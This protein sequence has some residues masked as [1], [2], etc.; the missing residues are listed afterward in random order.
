[1]PPLVSVLITVY[2]REKYVAAAI[3]SVLAQT[4]SNFELI[5]VDDGSKDRSVEIARRYEKDTRVRVHVNERNLGDYPNRNRAASLARGK[6]LKYVD[7]DDLI[8]PHCLEMMVEG[9]EAFP[10]AAFGV[11]RSVQGLVC[12]ALLSPRDAY[13]LHFFRGGLFGVGPLDTI[14]RR[15]AFEAIG[16]FDTAR[17]TGDSRCWLTL[18]RRS[19]V[20]IIV[21]CLV[22]WR[23]HDAQESIIERQ[24]YEAIADVTGRRFRQL[25][26]ALDAPDCPL[27]ELERRAVRSETVHAYARGIWGRLIRGQFRYAQALL[28][29][30]GQ[31]VPVL[32]KALL[33]PS[34][35]RPPVPAP[36]SPISYLPSPPSGSQSS[37]GASQSGPSSRG[38]VVSSAPSPRAEVRSQR[39]E[40]GGQRSEVREQ[41]APSANTQTTAH[42]ASDFSFQLSAF[43]VSPL[44]SVLIP[45]YNAEARLAEAVESVLAQRFTDWELI[46]VDDASTDRTGEIARGHADGTRIRYFRN[47]HNLGKWPNHNRCAELARGKHLK[48][49]HADDLLYPHCLAL[50]AGMMERYPEA[51]LG[52]SGAAGPYR[53]GVCLDSKTAL[54]SEFFGTPR[55]LEGPTALII[56]SAAFRALSGFRETEH[57]AERLLQLRLAN[58]WPMVLVNQ[59]AVFYRRFAAAS[60]LGY[61]KW[62]LNWAEGYAD[63]V[64]WLQ[65]PGVIL[66]EAEQREAA[67]NLLRYVWYRGNN[68]HRR[69]TRRVQLRER[70]GLLRLARAHGLRPR[71]VFAGGQER[72]GWTPSMNEHAL[73]IVNSVPDWT[74]FQ[75]SAHPEF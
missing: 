50:M 19:A 71:D 31:P 52:V 26:E 55:F 5:I 36:L 65:E 56:R 38:P 75:M 11:S 23:Q 44:V 24:S 47:E 43:S 57:P 22:W 39:T 35:P 66:N 8:Y 29:E 27:P 18:A 49:L 32:A 59:G 37:R 40:D 12:P 3:E 68:W 9:M 62:G 16:G 1:M 58:R 42:A 61:E 74:V 4:L 73:R 60:F 13:R 34:F 46:I 21:P 25:L 69:S 30:S 20:A 63:I 7:A 41:P 54:C 10:E 67:G 51:A 45:A 64:H 48:F 72:R 2:N 33:V 15:S 17:H 28:R 53:E 14:I 6:Y 70:L